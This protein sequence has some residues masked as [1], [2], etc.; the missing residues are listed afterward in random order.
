[1]VHNRPVTIVNLTFSIDQDQ[2]S[3]ETTVSSRY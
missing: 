3:T 2:P 1:M